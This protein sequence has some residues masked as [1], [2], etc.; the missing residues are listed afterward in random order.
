MGCTCAGPRSGSTSTTPPYNGTPV[1]SWQ[2]G[3]SRRTEPPRLRVQSASTGAVRRPPSSRLAHLAQGGLGWPL[4]EA[5]STSRTVGQSAS[6]RRSRSEEHTSELQSRRD[7]VCRL[8]LE[9]KKHT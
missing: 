4:R 5:S 8:L 7:L 2:L 1:S 9:K 6:T 3:S